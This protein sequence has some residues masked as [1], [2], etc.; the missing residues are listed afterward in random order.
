MANYRLQL[1][2]TKPDGW[3]TVAG[4]SPFDAIAN[5]LRAEW[6]EL[7]KGDVAIR[8]EIAYV[9]SSPA[10]HP[11][12]APLCVTSYKLKYEDS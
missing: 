11:N 10:T 9:Q 5:H 4:D 2:D 8:P 12:G 3:K 7:N 1:G 6:P